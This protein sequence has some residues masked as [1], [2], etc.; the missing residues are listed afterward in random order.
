MKKQAVIIGA[1]PAG[2]TAAYE[3]L[4]KTDI[5]PVIIEATG[6]IGGISK[7][8]NYKDNRMDMGGHRFFSKS[9]RVVNFWTAVLPLQ[10]LPSKDDILLGNNVPPDGKNDFPENSLEQNPEIKDDVMLIRKR[11]S[12][13]FFLRKFFDYPVSLSFRTIKNLGLVRMTKAGLSYLY[14]IFKK[15]K[16]V[17]LEDFMVNRFG[18]YLYSTFFEDYTQKVWG[19]PPAEIPADWGAQRIKGLSVTK[20]LSAAFK[21]IF[22]KKHMDSSL[23]DVETSLIESFYYPKYGPG[24]FWETVAALIKEKGGRIIFNQK[25]F[26]IET[27]QNSVAA[28]WAEDKDGNEIK[29]E[30]DYFMSSMP[31]K[32]LIEGFDKKDAETLQTARGLMYRD[33]ITIGLLL[34]ELEIKNDTDFKSYKERV[35][36]LWVYVQ[37]RD[38][39]IG[40]LQVFNNWSPYLVKDYE[41]TVWL[42]LEY[43]CNEGGDLWNMP[44]KDFI[45]FAAGELEK[46]G[47]IKRENVLDACLVKVPK[48]YPAYFG[49]YDRF[50]S[51]KNFT[52]RYEN[53]FLIGRNGQHKYNNMDHSML[54]AMEAVDNIIN[55]VKTKSNVWQVNAEKDY[56][57]AR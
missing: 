30:G 17:S 57:E 52:D 2:L 37:E 45:D 56:H 24:H 54:T 31:V 3:L 44:E 42:G 14:S 43:F 36:D 8:F 19:R 12:R 33:F 13:I 1:G 40:R 41:G 46:I 27:L 28:V 49:T 51:V 20:V 11:L 53:L 6:D 18:K 9:G 7:T 26:K 38:V 50:D 48:A 34:K 10:T 16:E 25:V 21:K 4:V 22:S 15:R 55:R 29:Y 32:D 35:A 47:I 5:S 23:K 39:K